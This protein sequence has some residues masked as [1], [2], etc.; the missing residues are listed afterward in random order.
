MVLSSSTLLLLVAIGTLAS[1]SM[2]PTMHKAL[3]SVSLFTLRFDPYHAS[4]RPF[5]SILHS[6]ATVSSNCE[7]DGLDELRRGGM[8]AAG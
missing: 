1:L 5:H 7:L 2:S 8:L 4:P 6:V 3:G